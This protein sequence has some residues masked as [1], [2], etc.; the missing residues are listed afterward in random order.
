MQQLENE[1]PKF[2]WKNKRLGVSSM[3][4]PYLSEIQAWTKE[5]A[6]AGGKLEVQ[7]RPL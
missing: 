5:E 3:G 1:F 6:H 2:H 4:W 7:E